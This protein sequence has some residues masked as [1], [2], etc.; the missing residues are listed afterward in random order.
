MPE[1]PGLGRQAAAKTIGTFILT[2]PSNPSPGAGVCEVVMAP[3][4]VS[5]PERDTSKKFPEDV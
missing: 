4:M 3:G 2:D 1:A 5:P